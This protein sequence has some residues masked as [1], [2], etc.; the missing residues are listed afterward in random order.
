MAQKMAQ[1]NFIDAPYFSV[2]ELARI[3]GIDR[4]VADQW[5]HRQLIK[6]IL[7]KR[8]GSLKRPFFS[9]RAI[10]KARLAVVL[11]QQLLFGP[12]QSAPVSNK[13]DSRGSR[14]RAR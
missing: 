7:V 9:V 14:H 4:A 3:A 11:N 12:G 13:S 2:A 6:P 5:V 10:F 1:V 8:A